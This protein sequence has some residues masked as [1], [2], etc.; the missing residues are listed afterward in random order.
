M[1]HAGSGVL[2]TLHPT[3]TIAGKCHRWLLADSESNQRGL[4]VDT[5]IGE[6]Y[7]SGGLILTA[8]L[9]SL[10]IVNVMGGVFSNARIAPTLTVAAVGLDSP[11]QHGY[12]DIILG[13]FR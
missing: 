4:G 11:L 6:Q 10:E 7:Q 1:K 12:K 8:C 13:G 2:K 9:R 3:S 5:D